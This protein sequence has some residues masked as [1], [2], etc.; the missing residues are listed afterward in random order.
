MTLQ[1]VL[2]LTPVRMHNV[3]VQTWQHEQHTS[4]GVFLLD[5]V[6]TSGRF[7]QQ[8][9]EFHKAEKQWTQQVIAL[10]YWHNFHF[11]NNPT[12]QSKKEKKGLKGEREVVATSVVVIHLIK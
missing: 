1:T 12:S 6:Q 9:L 4:C 11:L 8:Y 7:R 10:I 2:C 3:C 5:S